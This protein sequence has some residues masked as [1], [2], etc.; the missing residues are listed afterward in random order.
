[1]CG[2]ASNPSKVRE[3]KEL[4]PLGTRI[5]DGGQQYELEDLTE[6][7]DSYI[8]YNVAPTS[9]IPVITNDDPK[10]V[11][12]MPW[13]YDMKIQGRMIPL[14]NSKIEQAEKSNSYLRYDLQ[15]RRCVILF[16]G[17]YEWVKQDPTNKKTLKQPV[18]IQLNNSS[19]MPMAGIYKKNEDG[20]LGC[21]IIT[22]TPVESLKKVHH[23]M[24]FILNPDS[25][26][27]YLDGRL[28]NDKALVLEFLKNNLVD[29]ENLSYYPVDAAVGKVANN[30]PELMDECEPIFEV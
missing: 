15:E 22:T 9:Y 29:S 3:Y 11:Q 25:I 28:D 20:S 13:K 12:L 26:F 5:I 16:K 27:D 10:A 1:M 24:P 6:L 7:P 23:R 8:S 21:S 2:R 14:F 30:A 4:L 18:F 19:I 17:F